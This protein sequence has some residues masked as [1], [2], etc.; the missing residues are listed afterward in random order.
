MKT[1][2]AIAVISCLIAMGLAQINE[3]CLRRTTAVEVSDCASRLATGGDDFCSTCANT[4]IRFFQ[5]CARGVGVDQVKQRKST[6]YNCI[7]MY[8]MIALQLRSNHV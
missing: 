7:D 4:L 6:N 8:I 5:D 2:L 3:D 1:I